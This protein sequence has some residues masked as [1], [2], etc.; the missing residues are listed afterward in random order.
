MN[1]L[2]FCFALFCLLLTCPA[3]AQRNRLPFALQVHRS[4]LSAPVRRQLRTL[5]Q[6]APDQANGAVRPKVIAD[7]MYLDSTITYRPVDLGDGVYF[8]VPQYR[9]EFTQ[10]APESS[11]SSSRSPK[12]RCGTSPAAVPRRA[13]S[14][15][16]S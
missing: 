5:E 10:L 7:T 16:E 9:S 13:M 1:N 8:M 4:E 6:P 12:T 15:A 14:K 11:R 3:T 2:T